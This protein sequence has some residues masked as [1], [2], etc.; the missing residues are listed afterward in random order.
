MKN[1]TK[2][3]ESPEVEM[4]EGA[5]GPAPGALPSPEDLVKKKG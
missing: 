5:T 1:V 2:G 4:P 3:Y